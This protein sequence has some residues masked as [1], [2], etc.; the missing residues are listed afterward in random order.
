MSARGLGQQRRK[1][2]DPKGRVKS[3]DDTTRDGDLLTRRLIWKESDRSTFSF[4]GF[5][6]KSYKWFP[7]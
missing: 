5:A 3:I 4:F 2:E 7:R 6:F 1:F